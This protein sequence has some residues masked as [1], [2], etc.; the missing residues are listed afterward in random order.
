[1]TF[2]NTFKESIENTMNGIKTDLSDKIDDKLVNLDKGLK[3]LTSEVRDND[4]RQEQN[5]KRLEKKQEEN[6]RKLEARL[7]KLELDADRQKFAR[8]KLNS[9]NLD[10]NLDNISQRDGRREQDKHNKMTPTKNTTPK[11][12]QDNQQTE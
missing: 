2:L 3:T 10:S 12:K 9:R 8:T 5:L 7:N 11:D 6:Q 4:K 1:M